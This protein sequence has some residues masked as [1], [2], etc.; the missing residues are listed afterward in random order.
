VVKPDWRAIATFAARDDGLTRLML[1]LP[2]AGQRPFAATFRNSSMPDPKIIDS[3]LSQFVEKAGQRVEVCIYRLETDAGWSLEIVASDGTSTAWEDL[4]ATDAE[5][6]A[7]ALKAIDE[8]G[9]NSFLMDSGSSV[10]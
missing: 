1:E 5:A 4:F 10:H 8:E 9:I 2:L 3:P 7:E 6:H